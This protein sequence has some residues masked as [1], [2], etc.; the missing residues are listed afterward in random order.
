MGSKKRSAQIIALSAPIFLYIYIT[1]HFL[2]NEK[3]VKPPTPIKL[4]N[5]IL[6]AT[7]STKYA[8]PNITILPWNSYWIWPDF[9]MGHRNL[10]FLEHNCSFTNCYLF[11]NK[12]EVDKADVILLHGHEMGGIA[13]SSLEVL[14]K[15][16]TDNNGWPLFLY[17]NKES[18]T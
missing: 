18:P 14:K 17:F 6:E 9:G 15:T 16:R 12:S 8:A 1:T 3:Y 5:G 10:G 2:D 7:S 13:A 11:L 4:Y